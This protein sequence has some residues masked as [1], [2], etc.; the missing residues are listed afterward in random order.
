M[1]KK[2]RQNRPPHEVLPSDFTPTHISYPSDWK[3]LFATKGFM[4]ALHVPSYFAKKN[5]IMRILYRIEKKSDVVDVRKEWFLK[6]YRRI[7][8]NYQ[9]KPKQI[10]SRTR[11]GGTIKFE[12]NKW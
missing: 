1:E 5:E 2:D 3:R 11:L 6:R 8:E 4:I 12:A 7:F 9:P 10:T